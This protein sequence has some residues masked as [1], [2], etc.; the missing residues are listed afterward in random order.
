M[1]DFFP[2]GQYI[3]VYVYPKS[4]RLEHTAK[5]SGSGMTF[6]KNNN[7]NIIYLIVYIKISNNE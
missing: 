2:N 3:L 4:R 5:I 6:F 1:S 7:N